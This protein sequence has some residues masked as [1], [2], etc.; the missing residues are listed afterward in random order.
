MVFRLLWLVGEDLRLSLRI[1]G[2]KGGFL[3]GKKGWG[4]FSLVLFFWEGGISNKLIRG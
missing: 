2:V 3:G 1:L 4:N